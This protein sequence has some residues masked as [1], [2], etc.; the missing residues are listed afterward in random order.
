MFKPQ[1][2]KEELKPLHVDIHSGG[3]IGGWLEN[4]ARWCTYLRS[5]TG[6]VVVSISYRISPWHICPAAHEEVEDTV[7][8]HIDDAA[9]FGTKPKTMYYWW[10]TR[11]RES[12]AGCVSVPR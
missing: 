7:T 1:G 11:G 6:A 8:Y 5:Q 12:G 4:G 2:R 9:D 10:F 3:F